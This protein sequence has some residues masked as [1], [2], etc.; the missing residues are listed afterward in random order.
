MKKARRKKDRLI[1]MLDSHL[2]PRPTPDNADTVEAPITTTRARIIATKVGLPASSI[3]QP[4]P[5]MLN[6][7][8]VNCETP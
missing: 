5:V 4:A 2:I 3:I 1:L 6:M 7:P 8:E